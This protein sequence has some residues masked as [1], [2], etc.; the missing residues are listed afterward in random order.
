MALRIGEVA[1]LNTLRGMAALAVCWYHFSGNSMIGA[2][3]IRASGAYGWL[4]VEVFFVI[5]GFVI[6]LALLRQ[7]YSLSNYRTFLLKRVARLYPPYLASVA[8]GFALLVIYSIYKGQPRVNLDLADLLLHLGLLNDLFG[9]PWLNSIYWSLAIEF[10][11]YLMI[12]LFF[13]L[14]FSSEPWRRYV[15]YAA[16]VLPLFVLSSS[17]FLFRY[18][19]LFLMGIL[20]IQYSSGLV[21][22]LE[23]LTLLILS[24]IGLLLAT[25]LVVLCAAL[26]TVAA[27]TFLR[28]RIPLLDNLGRISY[29][30]YLLHSSLGSLVLFVLLRFTMVTGELE[31]LSVLL[32]SVFASACFA[33]VAYYLIELPAMRCSSRIDYRK[34]E[35]EEAPAWRQVCGRVL[36]RTKRIS[37]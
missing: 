18:S 34:S 33:T 9:R 37:Q 12:G 29:S 30:F 6:P 19:F 10:Q 36:R 16:F 8:V 1:S 11:F 28:R 4:G 17:I 20:T 7:R 23:Y 13:P 21:R 3:P 24:S 22:R 25:G 5:S 14:L 32:L 31:K 2:G 35:I 26:F 27:I 15:G